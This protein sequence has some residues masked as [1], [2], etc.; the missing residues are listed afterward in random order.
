MSEICLDC[1]NEIMGE[2][3]PKGRYI[4]SRELDLCENCGKWKRVV[5]RKRLVYILL[6]DIRELADNLSRLRKKKPSEPEL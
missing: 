6:D 5:I 2:A 1:L 3:E 4:L